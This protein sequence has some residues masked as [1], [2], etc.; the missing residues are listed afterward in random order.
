MGPS[1]GWRSPFLVIS[2][3]C[4]LCALLILTTAVES[5]RGGSEEEV[6]K[7]RRSRSKFPSNADDRKEE[8]KSMEI[9][10]SC[11]EEKEEDEDQI[12]TVVNP[13]RPN[14]IPK[15][16]VEEVTNVTAQYS[17]QSQ[18][19]IE[20]EKA[21]VGS[22]STS[23]EVFVEDFEFKNNPEKVILGST[24]VHDKMF[25]DNLVYDEQ[26]NCTK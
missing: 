21:I 11:N 12:E 23:H 9:K 20:S 26:I 16:V 24:P 8:R 13:L 4:L 14:L 1:Y 2:I 18:D 5:A 3:P 25:V 22:R 19:K 15:R 7:M 6:L 10:I 17:Q